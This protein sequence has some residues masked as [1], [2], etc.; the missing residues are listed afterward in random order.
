[1]TYAEFLQDARGDK[2]T[3]HAYHCRP[4]MNRLLPPID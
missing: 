3:P 1:M 4:A 2:Q